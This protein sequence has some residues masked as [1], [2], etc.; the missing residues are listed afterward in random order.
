MAVTVVIDLLSSSIFSLQAYRRDGWM[1]MAIRIRMCFITINEVH[2]VV[3]DIMIGI[4]KQWYDLWE[5]KHFRT[6]IY[7]SVAM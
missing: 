2:I 4:H 1:K 6:K 3:C 5:F 7:I